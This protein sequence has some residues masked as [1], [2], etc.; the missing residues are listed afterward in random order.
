[1]EDVTTAEYVAFLFGLQIEFNK[2]FGN[3]LQLPLSASNG[4]TDSCQFTMQETTPLFL[5]GTNR[6]KTRSF[7]G[8]IDSGLKKMDFQLVSPIFADSKSNFD[9]TTRNRCVNGNP[10]GDF[11]NQ[12]S[13]DGSPICV[14]FSNMNLNSNFGSKSSMTNSSTTSNTRVHLHHNG[15]AILPPYRPAPDYDSLFKDGAP[16]GQKSGSLEIIGSESAPFVCLE[17]LADVIRPL[18]AISTSMP[19]LNSVQRQSPKCMSSRSE[20]ISEKRRIGQSLSL[21][22]AA[23]NSSTTI[24]VEPSPD[25]R[26]SLNNN[27]SALIGISSPYADEF[28][29]V[30]KVEHEKSLPSCLK[31]N[32]STDA[33][34]YILS[35]TP[36]NIFQF[37]QM[38]NI[39]W[40]QDCRIIVALILIASEKNGQIN[41]MSKAFWS[42]IA[43]FDVD[44]HTSIGQKQGHFVTSVLHLK[45]SVTADQRRT[46]YH[47]QYSCGQNYSN[48]PES[49]VEFLEEINS[50]ELLVKG[51]T[52]M[53]N[54]AN[55]KSY[56]GQQYS[57][58]F[59]HCASGFDWSGVFILTHYALKLYHHHE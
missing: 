54:A 57:P 18:S 49:F 19:Y 2:R 17:N 32:S 26:V 28:M 34:E 52:E 58:I 7:A 35:V 45:D 41:Y 31:M 23:K 46:I 43:N 5:N 48:D 15:P 27:S 22:N 38:L 30:P 13:N 6:S 25:G 20:S 36:T 47:I 42:K 16:S 11:M 9:S 59:V 14:G 55:Q 37:E 50:L 33:I 39:V 4:K 10:S 24:N 44:L 53:L 51:E 12:P 8:K 56:T 1:M 3:I 21:E 29:T 40:I